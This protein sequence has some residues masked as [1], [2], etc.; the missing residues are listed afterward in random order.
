MV[1]MSEGRVF[2]NLETTFHSLRRTEIN[3]TSNVSKGQLMYIFFSCYI[4]FA[5]K[6]ALSKLLSILSIHNS[7]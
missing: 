3:I 1:G 6:I 5:I 4:L 2:P 7:F